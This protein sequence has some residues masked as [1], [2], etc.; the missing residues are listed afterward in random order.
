MMGGGWRRILG[1]PFSYTLVAQRQEWRWENIM[2][3][4]IFGTVFM[5][6]L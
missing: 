4:G 5:D 6:D 3:D 1:K 2:I